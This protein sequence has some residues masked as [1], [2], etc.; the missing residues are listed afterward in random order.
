MHREKSPASPP[1]EAESPREVPGP[2]GGNSLLNRDFQRL[3]HRLPYRV[4]PLLGLY[5]SLMICSRSSSLN[6]R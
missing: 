2:A 1:D 3:C 4:R 6:I 5:A